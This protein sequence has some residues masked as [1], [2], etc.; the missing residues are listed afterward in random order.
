MTHSLIAEHERLTGILLDLNVSP[1]WTLHLIASDNSPFTRRETFF[2]PRPIKRFRRDSA[3][4][5]FVI[6]RTACYKQGI[7]EVWTSSPKPPT[8]ETPVVF[9]LSLRAGVSPPPPLLHIP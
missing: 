4:R 3:S 7:K 2:I 6:M 5:V 8:S 1:T 9:L